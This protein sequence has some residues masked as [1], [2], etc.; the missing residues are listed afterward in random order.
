MDGWEAL[1]SSVI[2]EAFFVFL[3]STFHFEVIYFSKSTRA[4]N[5]L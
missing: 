2:I 3:L 5:K 4:Y 1:N